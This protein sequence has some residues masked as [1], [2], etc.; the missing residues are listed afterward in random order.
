MWPKKKYDFKNRAA[1]GP[2]GIKTGL[3]RVP[4]E[5]QVYTGYPMKTSNLHLM[6]TCLNKTNINYF[7]E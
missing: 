3:H 6:L 7:F 5:K 2:R 4:Y 1:A